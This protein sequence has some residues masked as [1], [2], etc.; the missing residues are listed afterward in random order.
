MDDLFRIQRVSDPRVSPD[1]KWVAY[2]VT[3]ADLAADKSTSRIW[4][5]SVAGGEPIPLTVKGSSASSPRWSPDGTYLGF[6]AARDGDESQVWLLNRL[7]GE[8][9]QLTTVKPGVSGFAWSPDGGRLALEVGDASPEQ[10]GDTTW[11]GAKAKTQRPYVID[12]LQFKR[13]G[14]GYLDRRRQ[15]IY[16]FDVRTKAA[17]RQVTSGDWDDNG[18]VWSPDGRFIAF[19]SNRD[20]VDGSDNSDIWVV[21]SGDTTKGTTTRRLTSEP[22]QDGSPAWS[23]DGRWIAYARQPSAEPI[24]LI[25]DPSHLA[26]IGADGGRP[27]PLTAALDREIRAPRWAPDGRSLYGILEDDGDNHLVR[28]DA[29]SGA[30]TR[31]VGEARSVGAYSVG[32]EGT[33]AALVSEPHLP[34]EVFVVEATPRQ[35]THTNRPLLDSLHLGEVREMHFKSRDGTPVEAFLYLP[36]DYQPGRRYPTL[37]RIH[38][39]PVSQYDRSFNPEAQVFAAHG[40]VVVNTNPRGSSGYG[41]RFSRAIFAD[42]GNKDYEDVMAAVDEAIRLGFADPQRLGVGGWSY[43]GILTNYVITKTGR[44]KA[45]ISGAS[46]ALY[47]S[48]YGHD[49]Y[50]NLWEIEL[51]VPW[52]NQRAWDRISP[53]WSVERITTPTL[54]MGGDRDWNVPISNSE[55]MYQAMRRLG[56]TTQLVVYPGQSHGISRPTYQKDRLERY[57]EWYDRFLTATPAPPR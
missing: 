26:V 20:S 54:W 10:A 31:L 11:I 49:H 27:R 56:R 8:A 37:L 18:P 44:F 5:V 57:L 3:T 19:T 52:R 38:G 53:F 1:G 45:A 33:I 36:P 30:V 24:A 55:Q 39:G 46:E 12:R 35:L 34:G 43:G 29:A 22:G 17:P 6:L 23:P 4:M 50:Q 9:E 42:W 2:T 47:T 28:V 48:N 40:Y 13:D 16:V 32:A 7:G 51:G 21:A 14:T 41:A 15:H 25:Y